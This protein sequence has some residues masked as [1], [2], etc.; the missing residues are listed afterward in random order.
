[1]IA[2]SSLA[3]VAV[4]LVVVLLSVDVGDAPG[5]DT[6]APTT[7]PVATTRV[8][9][10]GP[11]IDY[12]P[13]EPQTTPAK[14]TTTTTVTAIPLD[15]SILVASP[16]GISTVVGT[17]STSIDSGSWVVALRL[18]DGSLVAQSVWP[19]YQQPGDS[20]IYRIAEGVASPLITP[21]DPNNEWLRLHDVVVEGG[22]DRILYSKK[23]GVGFD[24][25]IEELF[26]VDANGTN[27][28]ALGVIGDWE[29]GPDRLSIGG[30]FIAG[31]TWTQIKRAPLLLDR[32]G[33]R[34]DG[35]RFGLAPG[36]SDCAVCPKVFTV[37]E[38]GTR[39]AW[40]EGDLVVV[41]ATDTAA[42][43]AEFSLT[44]GLGDH[45]DSL[46]LGRDTVIVNAYD[47]ATGALGRPYLY[48][49]DGTSTQLP[50][51]GWASYD[52]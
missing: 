14:D 39:L 2:A 1:M 40:V 35:G 22:I 49:F 28:V 31:E 20:T 44:N 25:A 11:A 13:T 29:T 3:V 30:G 38:T 33:N 47:P 50:V 21:S 32:G 41:I 34:L 23:S 26:L 36:Y 5:P 42:R 52:R 24:Q 27:E 12:T 16:T 15:Q 10:T 7:I 17:S 43:V 45:V 51:I 18:S 48:G 8:P 46:Q 37:D 9:D 19:G 4:L 6:L